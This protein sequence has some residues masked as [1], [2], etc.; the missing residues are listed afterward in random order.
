MF[1]SGADAELPGTTVSAADFK[2]GMDILAL[3]TKA[4]LISSKSEGRRL[5]DGGGIYLNNQVIN[6]YGRLVTLADFTDNRTPVMFQSTP[7]RRG[8]PP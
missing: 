8:R 2:D 1:G 4:G 3:L 7:P 6:D 5:M